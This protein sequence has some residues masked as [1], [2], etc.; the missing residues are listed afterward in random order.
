MET[1][2]E[3]VL[4]VEVVAVAAAATAAVTAAAAAVDITNK[5]LTA[6][7]MVVHAPGSKTVHHQC[8]LDLDTSHLDL[9]L[10]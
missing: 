6:A 7:L 10:R 5:L 1:A 3:G 8:M 9:N 4:E 2:D